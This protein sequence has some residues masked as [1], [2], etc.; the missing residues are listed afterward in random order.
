MADDIDDLLDEVE[1]KFVKKSKPEK[2]STLPKVR[3]TRYF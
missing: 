2:K 3:P 1:D